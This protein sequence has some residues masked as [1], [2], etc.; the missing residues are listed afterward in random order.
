MPRNWTVFSDRKLYYCTFWVTT[1]K[2]HLTHVGHKRCCQ[3]TNHHEVCLKLVIFLKGYSPF[4]WFF[5]LRY[6]KEVQE[7]TFWSKR[8]DSEEKSCK[9]NEKLIK[10][11]PVFVLHFLYET[12]TMSVLHL[13]TTDIDCCGRF[14]WPKVWAKCTWRTCLL[15]GHIEKTSWWRMLEKTFI[16]S[17]MFYGCSQT[18]NVVWNTV[19]VPITIQSTKRGY[20]CHTLS[21]WGCIYKKGVVGNSPN[22]RFDIFWP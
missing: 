4:I 1:K 13:A 3:N 12:I 18:F 20:T 2:S 17:L 9:T 15:S 21:V 6:L 16:V 11:K 22:M 14:A 7:K 8:L 19:Y 5:Q 10:I